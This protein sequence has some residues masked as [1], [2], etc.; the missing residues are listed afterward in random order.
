M[1]KTLIAIS[2]Y[3]YVLL[4]VISNI[5]TYIGAIIAS[6]TLR[7]LYCGPCKSLINSVDNA[8]IILIQKDGVLKLIG[9]TIKWKLT[10][11]RG[12][13]SLVYL[14]EFMTSLSGY[15]PKPIDQFNNKIVGGEFTY[16]SLT[17][18]L[19]KWQLYSLT[20]SFKNIL[21]MFYHR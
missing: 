15:S 20:N 4:I 10:N 17:I 11:L 8:R 12:V 18:L 5:W 16:N 1:W 6:I 14:M 9:V 21:H 19:L 2:R 13:S 7:W 3:G